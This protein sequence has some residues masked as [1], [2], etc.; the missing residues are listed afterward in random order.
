MTSHRVPDITVE[1]LSSQQTVVVPV[2]YLVQVRLALRRRAHYIPD[3]Q[4]ADEALPL[5]PL[6]RCL[7]CSISL[8][9]S[10]T[11]FCNPSRN[12]TIA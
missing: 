10:S 8:S 6:V 2:K 7:I 11:N 12:L 5:C 9:S 4:P 3:V 1:V